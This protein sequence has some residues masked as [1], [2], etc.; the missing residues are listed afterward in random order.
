MGDGFGE[1]AGTGLKQY[2]VRSQDV[3]VTVR[4]DSGR[5]RDGIMVHRGAGR[6]DRPPSLAR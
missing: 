1:G 3:A 6:A 4:N 5:G 2:R